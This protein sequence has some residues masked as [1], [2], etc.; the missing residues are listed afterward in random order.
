VRRKFCDVHHTTAWPIALEALQRTAAL[1]AIDSS[2]NG[3]TPEY[4]AAARAKHATPLLDDLKA[5]LNLPGVDT[6]RP[7][8]PAS[9]PQPRPTG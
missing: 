4:R 3:R 9:I 5:F 2:V 8:D 6:Y 1:F 7:H